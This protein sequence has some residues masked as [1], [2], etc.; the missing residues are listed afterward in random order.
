MEKGHK[1]L[2]AAIIIMVIFIIATTIMFVF[3]TKEKKKE[4]ELIAMGT[5]GGWDGDV[6]KFK[7]STMMGVGWGLV[8]ATVLSIAGVVLATVK[9]NSI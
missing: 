5:D 8:M 6:N 1:W 4:D 7:S 2:L 3:A 9:R